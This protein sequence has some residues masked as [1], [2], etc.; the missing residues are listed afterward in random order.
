LHVRGYRRRR[1]RG[2][3]IAGFADSILALSFSRLREA[4]S[5]S[6]TRRAHSRTQNPSGRHLLSNVERANRLCVLAGYLGS[7]TRDFR[8]CNSGMKSI[9]ERVTFLFVLACHGVR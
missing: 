8:T 4:L 6:F 1:I 7:G 2:V 9:D 5:R 3:R